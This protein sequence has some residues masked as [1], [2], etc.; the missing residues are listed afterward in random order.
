MGQSLVHCISDK[1]NFSKAFACK[2]S[3]LQ[4]FKN[5]IYIFCSYKSNKIYTHANAC[6]HSHTHAHALSMS[7]DMLFILG[8]Y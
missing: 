7:T 4:F 1:T 3:I 2:A 8:I 5:Y 6:M